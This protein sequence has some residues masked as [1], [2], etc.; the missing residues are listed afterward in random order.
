MV[1]RH[2]QATSGTKARHPARPRPL[3]A[4][5][6]WQPRAQGDQETEWV[7]AAGENRIT[8]M[9]A[10]PAGLG[11]LA[12]AR[13]GRAD[14]RVR[15]QG[16]ATARRSSSTRTVNK[17]DRPRPSSRRA[18]TPGSLP[19]ARASSSPMAI[20]PSSRRST[21]CSTSGSIQARPMPSP[22]RSASRAQDP[23]RRRR[24]PRQGD[25]SRRL[26]PASRLV[27]SSPAGKLRHARRAPFDVVLT[28]GFV[29][30]EQGREDVEVARQRHRAAG[31]DQDSGADILRLWVASDYSDDLR[32]GPEILKTFV[33]TYRKL[34]N[35]CAGCSARWR[36]HRR[37]DPRRRSGLDAR[38]GAADAAPSRRARPAG[39]GG[40]PHLRLQEGRRR[41]CRSS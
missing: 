21:T 9:I 32:I 1:H 41:C 19:T 22:W 2:G 33:E 29:L 38:A 26:G 4:P 17:R 18:P 14:R 31:R 10:E 6:R 23:S 34:R 28:H 11:D 24:R 7:P 13:L 16:E 27:P 36:I 8:G 37:G 40:L 12:P 39:R 35:T 15:R 5:T 20:P 3:A 30:D 25:V